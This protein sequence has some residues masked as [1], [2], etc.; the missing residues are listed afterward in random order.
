[1]TRKLYYE[2][3]CQKDFTATVINCEA[4]GDAYRICLDQTAFFPEGGGQSG[5]IG[6]LN[7]CQVVDTQEENALI[8]HYTKCPL[9][10]GTQ[11]AGHLNWETRFERMQQH[12]GEHIV[13]GLV[14]KH[15]HY[16]NV[17]F[18][19]GETE[20][21]LDF[22]GPITK[23][24][25]VKIEQ[26]ANQ[27]VWDNIPIEIT[28]PDKNELKTLK[29]RSKI[30]IQGQVRIVTI[31]EIDVCACCA[32]HVSYTGEIGLIKLT[33]IQTHRGGVRIY[34]SAGSRAL[35]DYQEKERNTKAISVLLSAKEDD[36]ARAVERLKQEN[37]NLFG[38]ILQLEKALIEQ[39]AALVPEGTKDIAF[40]EKE[41][42]NNTAREFVNLL[43]RHCTGTACVFTGDD[44]DGYRYI[45]GSAIE[46]VRPL[47]RKLNEAFQGKG[48]GKAEM[49]QG[50]LHGT[51]EAI[52]KI[53]P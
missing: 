34:L 10:P 3:S 50:S 25:L 6:F 19:L 17:G 47:C 26:E 32:P 12:S 2:N 18:H 11:V 52:E 53:L 45:L 13:S 49:A 9:A 15:F 30:E 31:P 36:T 20:V 27:A 44:T 48:G 16:N 8:W 14:H 4:I 29:Y 23:D 46:D 41:L 42:D 38:K 39:K 24:E 51:R 33:H 43:T 37:F 40:F 7:D 28:Y 35:A 22:D 5:D 21:T 1:M